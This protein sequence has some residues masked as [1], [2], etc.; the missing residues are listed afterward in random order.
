MGLPPSLP[1]PPLS[2]SAPLL[3]LEGP[4][5]DACALEARGTLYMSYPFSILSG[6]AEQDCV[7]ARTHTHTHTH[8]HTDKYTKPA[9]SPPFAV[10]VLFWRGG[11]QPQSFKQSSPSLELTG[12]LIDCSQKHRS[13]PRS[14]AGTLSSTQEPGYVSP[15]P[16]YF[17]ADLELARPPETACQ[18]L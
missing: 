7:C 5:P 4:E 3:S 10:S 13:P 12:Q 16:P 2:Q 18:L 17:T 15:G 11:P 8:T 9:S 14:W 1:P 6:H